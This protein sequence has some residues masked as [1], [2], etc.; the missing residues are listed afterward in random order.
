MQINII[1]LFPDYFLPLITTS[2]VG[3]AHTKKIISTRVLNLRDFGLG[4]YKHV[5]DRP[6]GGG[7]GMVLMVEPIEKA[8]D[9]L[10]VRK[11]TP[12]SKII[13]T[14]AK[15]TLFTQ[16]TAR[17]MTT[18]STLTFICGHYEGVDERVAIH[19]I[20]EEMRIGDYV[21]SGGEPAVNVMVDAISRLLPGTLGNEKSLEFESHDSPGEL[22]SPQYT[23]PP[24]YNGHE[25]PTVLLSGN[26]AVINQWRKDNRS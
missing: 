15:G 5:D 18:L 13:L 8:L 2:V 23:R 20:D 3:R 16:A 26:H 24:S 4:P 1:T 7:P 12:D 17:D 22:A 19:F 9:S 10:K 14:S 25:V 11:G 21:L 6:F